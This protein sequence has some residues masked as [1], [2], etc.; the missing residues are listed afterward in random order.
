MNKT[1]KTISEAFISTSFLLFQLFFS[2]W[3]TK[4]I[5]T[6]YG[7]DL[8]SITQ[9]ANQI[10]GY[11]SLF[12]SGICAAYQY[13]M[14]LPYVKRKF[15]LL[16]GLYKDLE[17]AMNKI[18]FKMFLAVCLIS[19]I[20]PFL[21]ASNT[22]SHVRS[23]FVF[24]L[25]GLR[26]VLPYWIILAKKNI[27]IIEEKQFI[28]SSIDSLTSIVTIL[29]EI[30]MVKFLKLPLEITLIS[31]CGVILI[32]YIIYS[33]YVKKFWRKHIVE[34]YDKDALIDISKDAKK[35]TGDILVHQ[36]CGLAN[37]NIDILILSAID[38]FSVTVYANYNSVINY[39]VSII[40]GVIHNLRATIGLKFANNDMD[41]YDVFREILAFN[42]VCAGIVTAVFYSAINDFITVWLG[43]NYIVD[44][45]SVLLFSFI[46]L[47]K[48]TSESIYSIRDANGLYKESK[49]YTLLTAIVNLM[50]S[51]GTVRW[52]GIKGLLFGTVISSYAIMDLGN[53]KLVFH[54]VFNKRMTIYVNYLCALFSGVITAISSM[55]FDSIVKVETWSMFIL[56][57]II[58]IIIA[59]I[60]MIG[61]SLIIDSYFKHFIGRFIKWGR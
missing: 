34:K 40:N 12:E 11:L 61:I 21:L 35:M 3:R 7:T 14:Y 55:L 42:T 9:A 53:N 43:S 13:K 59:S 15:G 33:N 28:V 36:I 52:F 17:K 26:C 8:N 18:G 30:I 6:I 1:K 10:Y 44:K 27:L 20:Y 47:R 4:L 39:P 22:I 49:F 54:K 37:N 31:G 2:F 56:K 29:L 57:T 60:S 41:S 32:S 46:L 16:C 45:L 38:V 25:I 23:C 50:I 19:V 24:L 51:L 48:L 58:L 5:I